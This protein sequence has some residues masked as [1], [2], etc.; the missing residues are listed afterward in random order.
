MSA[1]RTGGL[2]RKS[3]FFNIFTHI[4]AYFLNFTILSN[5]TNKQFVFHV[6]VKFANT[7]TC[8]KFPKM[9]DLFHQSRYFR[10]YF[11]LD[12]GHFFGTPCMSPKTHFQFDRSAD[13]LGSLKKLV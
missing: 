1:I 12:I 3:L 8:L 2:Q 7:K 11:Y 6:E 4:F 9:S 10:S 5:I 13:Y